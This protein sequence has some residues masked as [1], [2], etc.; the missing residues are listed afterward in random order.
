MAT[1]KPP[2]KRL[3]REEILGRKVGHGELNI[4]GFG[5]VG[6]RALTMAEAVEVRALEGRAEQVY[7]IISLGMID[8][9]MTLADVEQ[10]ASS[11]AAGPLNAI[12]EGIAVISGMSEGAG[13]DAY[14]SA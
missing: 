10:W 14:K 6:I 2:P 4:E 8:P 11:D 1:T 5:T 3:T 12:S 7:L 9:P 13:K